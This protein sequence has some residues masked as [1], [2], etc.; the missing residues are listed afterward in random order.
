M[1]TRRGYVPTH[2]LPKDLQKKRADNLAQKSKDPINAY[3]KVF[4]QVPRSIRV[5]LLLRLQEDADRPVAEYS[6][7][8]TCLTLGDKAEILAV[9][10]HP[11]LDVALTAQYSFAI[12]PDRKLRGGEI[13]GLLRG[14]G[15]SGG[16]NNAEPK[17]Q[18]SRGK[19]RPRGK[20]P[21]SRK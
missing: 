5:A 6:W 20:E 8:I 10:I 2:L 16:S 15:V 18:P 21:A 13:A 3:W 12:D 1:V 4:M 11:D 19:P 9:G 14:P 7:K 17:R